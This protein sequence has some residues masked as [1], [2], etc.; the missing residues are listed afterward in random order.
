MVKVTT[1]ARSFA[2]TTEVMSGA[3]SE[4]PAGSVNVV[5]AAAAPPRV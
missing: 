1:P 3:P 2:T 4:S 5:A